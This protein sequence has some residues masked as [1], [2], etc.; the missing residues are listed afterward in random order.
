MNKN[1]K[2][3]KW[4]HVF[5][6]NQQPRL[7]DSLQQA[8]RSYKLYKQITNNNCRGIEP[9]SEAPIVLIVMKKSDESEDPFTET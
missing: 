6:I 4:T 5:C 3:L 9:D 2:I 8:S 7:L 1:N